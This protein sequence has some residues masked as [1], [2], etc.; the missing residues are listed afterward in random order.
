MSYFEHVEKL[1][2]DPILELMWEF[3]K[4]TRAEKIDLSVG[5]YYDENLKQ[6][7]L[8]SIKKTEEKLLEQEVSKSYLPIDG[9]PIFNKQIKK[10]VFGEKLVAENDQRIFCAQAVGGTGALRVGGEFLSKTQKNKIYLSSPT[11]DNHFKVF[12]AASLETKLYP[13]YDFNTHQVDFEKLTQFFMGLE[14]NSVVLLHACCH[15]PTGADLTKEQWMILSDIIK[16]KELIPFFDMAYQG[17][18]QDL[19]LDAFAV[20]YFLEQGH[21]MLIAY[22]LSKICGLYAER[23]GALLLVAKNEEIKNACASQIKTII[24]ANYSN[25]PK[26]GALVVAELFSDEELFLMWRKELKQMQ[27][28]IADIR[29]VFTNALLEKCASKDFSYL[30]SKKGMF[31]F[32]NLTADQVFIMKEQFGIYMT[33]NGRINIAGINYSNIPYIVNAI[34]T[35]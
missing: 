2:A 28:R 23:V 3:K 12:A 5:I 19:D 15:N 9:D 20:R 7:I 25:P 10:I 32:L 8:P 29:N 13:Y 35:I 26:H 34:N 27:K 31:C 30:F 24:R 17:F 18:G 33:K 14:I 22:S 11:W 1:P 6:V 16:Q 4:D 21:E